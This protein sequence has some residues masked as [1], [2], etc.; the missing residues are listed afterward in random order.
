MVKELPEGR[1]A[2]GAPGLLPVDGVQGLVDEQ[3]QGAQDEGPRWS[4]RGP[5][6]TQAH[7]ESALSQT[8]RLGGLHL[9][10]RLK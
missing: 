1:A 4:L 7:F 6:T 2:V 8:K 10:P 5:E 3:P 9:S